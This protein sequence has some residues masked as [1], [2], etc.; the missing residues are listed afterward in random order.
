MKSYT[1]LL[2]CRCELEV[3]RITQNY[4]SIGSCL[5]Q[6][7]CIVL[8]GDNF[9]CATVFIRIPKHPILQN[10]MM[11]CHGKHV[12]SYIPNGFISMTIFCH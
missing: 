1:K 8:V 11:G 12:F 9:M 6:F 7:T 3:P 10:C 4:I 2:Q 5:I